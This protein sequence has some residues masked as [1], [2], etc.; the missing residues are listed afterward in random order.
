MSK[1]KPEPVGLPVE[2][3]EPSSLPGP[4]YHIVVLGERREEIMTFDD[5][6]AFVEAFASV[7]SDKAVVSSYA[8]YGQ[9]LT[10]RVVHSTRIELASGDHSVQIAASVDRPDTD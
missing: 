1:G 6:R 5:E 7:K 4:Q 9:Q 8:F 10:G 2:T 3:E